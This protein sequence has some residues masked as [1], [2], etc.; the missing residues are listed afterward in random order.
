VVFNENTVPAAFLDHRTTILETIQSR[1][2]N[3]KLLLSLK[4]V[5]G[6]NVARRTFE[7]L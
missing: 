7:C 5:E 1:T 6:K 3:A 2:R 4:E